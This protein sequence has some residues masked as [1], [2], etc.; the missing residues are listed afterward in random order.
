MALGCDCDVVWFDRFLM[1]S[2]FVKKKEL[3]KLFPK[4]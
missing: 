4:V 2:V 1:K 3:N